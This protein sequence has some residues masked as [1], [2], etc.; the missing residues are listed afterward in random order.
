MDSK[1][2]NQ[3]LQVADRPLSNQHSI[4]LSFSTLFEHL[5]FPGLVTNRK[6]RILVA[7]QAF[8]T[9]IGGNADVANTAFLVHYVAEQD[10]RLLLDGLD[11][12]YEQSDSLLLR[13]TYATKQSLRTHLILTPLPDSE[14]VLVTL[15]KE[16]KGSPDESEGERRYE[17]LQNLLYVTC[18]N[19]KS[20]VVSIQG[21]CNL[22]LESLSS[23]DDNLLHYLA[24]IQRNADRLGKM[25]QDI[26]DFS[27]LTC[28]IES[29]QIVSLR[30][31]LDNI[32]AEHYVA[33]KQKAIELKL[34]Q[35]LPDLFGEPEGLHTLF[36]NLI[37]NAIKYTDK[38]RPC[39]EIGWEE[40]PR[41]HA[42][43]VR[44]NG[45]G[46]DK[47]YHERLFNLFERASASEQIEGTGVGLAIVKRI[48]ERH[49]GRIR[50]ASE[51]GIG[52]TVFF[53]L[54]KPKEKQYGTGQKDLE[55]RSTED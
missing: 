42:F 9:Q 47:K 24:R 6:G 12:V 21:F 48:V 49:S 10:R 14:Q 44:D 25:V 38:R 37:D 5:P 19:L 45:A 35:Q 52:S 34:P 28:P 29:K 2:E 13:V 46:V 26:L 20:P 8:E 3:N 33:I 55:E 17:E 31:I 36:S 32:R 39:I 43:W 18:H 23:E 53:T 11:C 22:I 4:H 1:L 15:Q 30:D 54:P 27:K 7:N 51:P 16:S 41:F 40:K 50:F